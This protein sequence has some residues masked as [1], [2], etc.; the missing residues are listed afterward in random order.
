MS[1]WLPVI[2]VPSY[3]EHFFATSSISSPN[4]ELTSP[5]LNNEASNSIWLEASPYKPTCKAILFFIL[6]SIIF[7]PLNS[8]FAAI[9][10][11][12]SSLAVISDWIAFNE[13]EP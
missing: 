7:K 8:Q 1:D 11:T 13:S 4:K 12:S 3:P 10:S 5:A 6:P 9:R 2:V